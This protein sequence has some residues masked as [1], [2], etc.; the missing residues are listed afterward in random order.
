MASTDQN[1]EPAR[2]AQ[3]VEAIPMLAWSAGPDGSAEFLTRRWLEYTGLS[4]EEASDWG[5]TAAVHTEDRDRL[6]DFW[7][8]LLTSGEAGEIE[9]PLRRHDGD[10][11]W[12]LFRVEPVRDNH[13]NIFKWYGANTDIEDRKRAEAL[14]AAEK[15]TLEM[16][17]SGACLADILESLCLTIDAQASDVKSAVLLMDADGMHLRPATGPRFPKEFLEAITPVKIG[18]CV[19]SC[20]TAAFLK[21]RVIVSDIA[22]DPLWADY[23]EF[24]LSYGFRAACSQ[25]LFSKNQHVLGTFG[26]Y[27]P[28]VRTPSETDLRLIEGAGL[29]FIGRRPKRH[30]HLRYSVLRSEPRYDP[31]PSPRRPTVFS[32]LRREV[33]QRRLAPGRSSASGAAVS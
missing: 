21:Q 14:L 3:D 5:W 6:M 30:V 7:R 18:P 22:T 29:V 33:T 31:L 12:F 26:M 25:P 11:R 10:Y 1:A 2:Q 9:A 24:A 32:G 16:I 19:G 27:Y 8:H 15:R 4:A 28:E 20:G 23:R 17:A 13:G